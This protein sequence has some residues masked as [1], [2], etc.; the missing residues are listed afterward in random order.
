MCIDDGFSIMEQTLALTAQRFEVRVLHDGVPDPVFTLRPKGLMC[1]RLAPVKGRQVRNLCPTT[2]SVPA[3]RLS[4]RVDQPA[5]VGSGCSRPGS[6]RSRRAGTPPSSVY[7]ASNRAP[8][9]ARK[10]TDMAKRHRRKCAELE[11]QRDEHEADSDCVGTDSQISAAP[12][13]PERTSAEL[14]TRS[15]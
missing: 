11:A 4:R 3:S 5:S 1:P 14:R 7:A 6:H 13:L 9:G 2:R 8:P 15:H 12:S 10:C